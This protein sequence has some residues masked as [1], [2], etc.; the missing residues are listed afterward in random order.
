MQ[1]IYVGC[2]VE[3]SGGLGFCVDDCQNVIVIVYG[4]YAVEKYGGRQSFL[5]LARRMLS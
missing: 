5:N 2:G 4:T 3:V 1:S